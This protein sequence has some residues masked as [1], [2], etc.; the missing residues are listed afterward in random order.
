MSQGEKSSLF[1]V[2]SEESGV[3]GEIWALLFSGEG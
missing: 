2:L 1:N 3:F